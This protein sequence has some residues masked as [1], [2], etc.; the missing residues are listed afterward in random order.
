MFRLFFARLEAV[1][2]IPA[3][4]VKWIGKQRCT[5]D[6]AHLTFAH[7]LLD[8]VAHLLRDDIALLNID[9]VDAAR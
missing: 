3:V 5:K 7:T 1:Y 6:K 4:A 8:L 9:F 2:V